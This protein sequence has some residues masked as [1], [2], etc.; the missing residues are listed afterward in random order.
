M[1]LYPNDPKFKINKVLGWPKSL[2]RFFHKTVQKN[3]NKLVG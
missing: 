1:S 2:F 3:L